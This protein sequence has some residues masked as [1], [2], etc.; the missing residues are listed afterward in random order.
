MMVRFLSSCHFVAGTKVVVSFGLE[1][2]KKNMICSSKNQARE[3][4]KTSRNSCADKRKE[5]QMGRVVREKGKNFRRG[6]VLFKT[7]M[8]STM[9]QSRISLFGVVKFLSFSDDPVPLF[10]FLKT[11]PFPSNFI[12]NQI[13]HFSTF[14]FSPWSKK[15]P[16]NRPV[17]PRIK[18]ANSSYNPSR[19]MILCFHV[20]P[21]K[22]N[23]LSF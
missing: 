9:L 13:P 8:N 5:L 17:I 18:L 12:F 23:I 16:S 6:G 14:Q 7:Q 4:M 3:I 22:R 19:N 2:E 1:L 10:N 21:S 11:S 15:S 20:R